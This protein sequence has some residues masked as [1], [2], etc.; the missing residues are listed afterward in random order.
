MSVT[1]SKPAADHSIKPVRS[2]GDRASERRHPIVELIGHRLA[3]YV[4]VG[5]RNLRRRCYQRLAQLGQFRGGDQGRQIRLGDLVEAR[6]KPGDREDGDA[7]L[8]DRE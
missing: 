7:A 8:R 1:L 2:D 5:K 3:A 4:R 6:A